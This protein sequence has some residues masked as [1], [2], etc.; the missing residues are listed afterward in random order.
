MRFIHCADFHID[1]PL[2][3][4]LTEFRQ[5]AS[6]ARDHHIDAVL[7][8]GDLFDSDRVPRTAALS[9]RRIILDNPSVMFYYLRGNHDKNG[10]FRPDAMPDNL[11]CFEDTWT[12]YEPVPGIT[13]AGIE[14]GGCKSDAVSS[15]ELRADDFNLV[16]LH[17]NPDD[18]GNLAHRNIDY[19]AM[20]HIHKPSSR[21][22]DS[23]TRMVYPGCPMG[24][25]WDE[26]GP[27]GFVAAEVNDYSHYF[28]CHF[29]DFAP[30]HFYRFSVDVT[31]CS[32]SEEIL[33]RIQGCLGAG[34]AGLIPCA[35]D[36]I[37][38][39]LTGTPDPDAEKNITYMTAS[40][41]S[42]YPH[43]ELSDR[44][45]I[46]TVTT[47]GS[48]ASDI[49]GIRGNFIRLVTDDPDLDPLIKKEVLETGLGLLRGDSL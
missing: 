23:R 20:G 14:T 44:T 8:S 24:R 9:V 45:E 21:Q 31:G 35:E 47:D 10:V 27:K 48:H 16:M 39:D 46:W 36:R 3:G 11:L 5:M 2:S 13:I 42:T 49:K 4:S 30:F 17:G 18:F 26:T 7:I 29:V 1:S 38:I 37:R 33:D 32:D 25:G 43:I 19:A 22:I 12:Y 40:L 28:D 15:L 6:Y 34:E 41:S